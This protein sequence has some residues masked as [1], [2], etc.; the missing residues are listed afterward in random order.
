MTRKG[1]VIKSLIELST[2][3]K[4]AKQYALAYSKNPK[5]NLFNEYA[6][7]IDNCFVLITKA[8]QATIKPKPR[9]PRKML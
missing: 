6:L 2:W 3:R 7:A 8:I 4:Y 1:D 5:P 9:R